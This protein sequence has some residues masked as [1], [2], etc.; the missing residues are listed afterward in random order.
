LQGHL[1]LLEADPGKIR[2]WHNRFMSV[3][4]QTHDQLVSFPD[5][6]SRQMEEL[7]SAE[8]RPVSDLLQDGFRLY[9]LRKLDAQLEAYRASLPETKYTEADIEAF[10]DEARQLSYDADKR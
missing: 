5:A 2:I 4:I 6:V 1:R 7:A 9:R 10:V 3:A 8:H